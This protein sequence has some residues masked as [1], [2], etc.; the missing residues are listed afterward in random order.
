MEDCKPHGVLIRCLQI[1]ADRMPYSQAHSDSAII[2]CL[3]QDVRPASIKDLDL[4]E[5][6][7]SLLNICWSK[8]PAGRPTASACS[9]TLRR[10]IGA[11]TIGDDDPIDSRSS[12][13]RRAPETVADYSE[14]ASKRDKTQKYGEVGDDCESDP[15]PSFRGHR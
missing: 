14:R 1:T 12:V 13:K 9:Q 10:E 6:I 8:A 7:Q 11:G 15:I 4:S 2:R 3:M 5:S